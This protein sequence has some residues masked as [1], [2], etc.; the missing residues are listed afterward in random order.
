MMAPSEL[1]RPRLTRHIFEQIVNNVA[2]VSALEPITMTTI[3][4]MKS[5]AIR[6]AKAIKSGK[7][8]AYDLMTPYDVVHIIH[9]ALQQ[10]AQCEMML[11]RH[12]ARSSWQSFNNDA[13]SG[14]ARG[15]VYD[16]TPTF[17]N[18]VQRIWTTRI[19]NLLYRNP[20]FVIPTGTSV[21]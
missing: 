10:R 21:F 9:I 3:K 12:W 17:I 1:V 2:M 8:R 16:Y 5:E 19:Q 11:S 15:C 14:L 4:L 18:V 6:T 7:D 20:G 13:L